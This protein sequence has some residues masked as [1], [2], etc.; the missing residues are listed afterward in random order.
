MKNKV[1]FVLELPLSSYSLS[2]LKEL[3]YTTASKFDDVEESCMKVQAA[4]DELADKHG[5]FRMKILQLEAN[6]NEMK[7]SKVVSIEKYCDT[8][9]T[10][11]RLHLEAGSVAIQWKNQQETIREY[12]AL[13]KM[14]LDKMDKIRK[15]TLEFGQLVAFPGANNG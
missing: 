8:E 2:Q 10:L 11:R 5:V 7:A 12:K 3:Y 13:I 1:S 9:E 15:A 4:A 6:L 14:Y